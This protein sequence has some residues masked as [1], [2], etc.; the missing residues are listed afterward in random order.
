[1]KQP[2]VCESCTRVEEIVITPGGMIRVD[3]AWL[4]DDE[5]EELARADGFPDFQT[6]LEF[7]KGRL[8]F[9]GH[10]IHWRYLE[11]AS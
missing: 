3:G 9:R 1:M 8:P 7:W 6:M 4:E 10:I 2:W 5:R 11:R